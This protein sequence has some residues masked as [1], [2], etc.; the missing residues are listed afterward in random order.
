MPRPIIG[1]HVNGFA[2]HVLPENQIIA[3]LPHVT[4]RQKRKT[5]SQ[6]PVSTS[7]DRSVIS[8]YFARSARVLWRSA[9]HTRF[10]HTRSVAVCRGPTFRERSD[11]KSRAAPTSHVSHPSPRRSPDKA[12]RGRRWCTEAGHGDVRSRGCI[13]PTNRDKQL[14]VLTLSAHTGIRLGG[15]PVRTPGYGFR[16]R[17]SPRIRG[18]C[19]RTGVVETGGKRQGWNSL[20]SVS[21]LLS[22]LPEAQR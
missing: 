5:C 8:P 19:P 21:W 18:L 9:P 2:I 12:S 22:R 10:H 6:K 20:N 15:I 14:I 4:P 11:Q 7:D 16:S 17:Q 13:P 3:V 1:R